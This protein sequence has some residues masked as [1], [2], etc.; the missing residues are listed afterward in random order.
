MY[1]ADYAR[2][3]FSRAHPRSD[4]LLASVLDGKEDIR[5]KIGDEHYDIHVVEGS[6]ALNVVRQAAC[7]VT[8]VR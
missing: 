8:V 3:A 7:T 5:K 4:A 6:T 2:S 1:L